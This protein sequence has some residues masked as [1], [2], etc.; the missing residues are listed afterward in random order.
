M[1]ASNNCLKRPE[2]GPYRDLYV[3][4]T[5]LGYFIAGFLSRI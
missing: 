1:F 4:K 3:N 5:K 2:Q